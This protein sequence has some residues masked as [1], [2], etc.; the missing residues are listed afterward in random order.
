MFLVNQQVTC[1]ENHK[2][3]NHM[4]SR[5]QLLVSWECILLALLLWKLEFRTQFRVTL[6]R[7]PVRRIAIFL[8]NF[9]GMILIIPSV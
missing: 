2:N 8:F 6:Q 7:N 9:Y 3:G 5:S 1:Y 4:E